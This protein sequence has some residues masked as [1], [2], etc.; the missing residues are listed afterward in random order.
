[1]KD[2]ILSKDTIHVEI[3]ED[4]SFN[5]TAVSIGRVGEND[6]TQLEI[7][8]P[9][10]LNTFWAYIDFKKPK[11]AKYKTYKLD[12][13]NNIIEYDVPLE[14]LDENGNLEVQ[15]IFQNEQ[16]LI[17]KSA[18]KKFVVLGSIEAVADIV[19]QEDFFTKAQK[20]L[21]KIETDQIYKPESENAQSGKAVAEA[22]SKLGT[23]IKIDGIK[24]NKIWQGEDGTYIV[25]LTTIQFI[26]KTQ[27]ALVFGN[28]VGLLVDNTLEEIEQMGLTKGGYYRIK[29]SNNKLEFVE[30]IS[31]LFETLANEINAIPLTSVS[32]ITLLANKWV[33]ETSPYSQRV[34]VVGV[35]ENSKI[36]LNPTIE[37][38]NIFHNKDIA[39]VVENDEGIVTVYCIG[40][41]PTNDYT[42][43]ATV[44]EVVVY[45]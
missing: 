15:L 3:G 28:K 24:L 44:T 13:V 26:L 30:K 45:G 9:E 33:G 17:W 31:G 35:T 22:I 40:Q 43:Q 34:A 27:S 14:L 42:L 19:I 12:I 21:S 38:L 29:L 8:I 1:M 2:T 36:D 5:C 16:G 41:K 6:I 20:I 32:S 4:H 25:R 23:A 39:F 7:T 11:G 10:E 37:Q 18:I